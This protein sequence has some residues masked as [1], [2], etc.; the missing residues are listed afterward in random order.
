MR[1]HLSLP[2]ATFGV[3]IFSVLVLR[4]GIWLMAPGA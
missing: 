4:A 3:L 2:I 1:L